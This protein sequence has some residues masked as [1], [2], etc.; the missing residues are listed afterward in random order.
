M[1]WTLYPNFT[2]AELQCKHT[3]RCQ[4]DTGFMARLQK[5]RELYDRPMRITSGYR[6][7]S[8]PAEA[9]KSEPGEH[10]TGHA[11]DVAVQGP[12]AL[13]LIA[14]ALMCGF[15]RIGVQQKGEGRFIHLGD[16]PDFPPGIWSY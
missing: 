14:A 7:P 8:H 15:T 2:E 11:V 12:A 16:S 9:S 4:M 6:D 13:D 1:D 10:T 3:G 5:L